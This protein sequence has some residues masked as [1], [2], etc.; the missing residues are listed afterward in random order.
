MR[1][2]PAASRQVEALIEH[3]DEELRFDVSDRLIAAVATAAARIQ[4]EPHGG[5][6]APRPYPLLKSF[7]FRWIKEHRYWFGWSMAKGYPVLTNVFYDTADIENRIAP[8][9]DKDLPL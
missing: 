7:G 1:Q 6:P 8:D 2:T 4:A 5:D 3:F 9:D